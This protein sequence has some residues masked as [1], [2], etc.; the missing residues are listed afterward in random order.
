MGLSLELWVG[1]LIF[2]QFIVKIFCLRSPSRVIPILSIFFLDGIKYV[3][4]T[5]ARAINEKDL[6]YV[7]LST[8]AFVL[9]Q[10]YE[11]ALNVIRKTLT[12][13]RLVTKNGTP[14]IKL[15]E[16]TS[17]ETL[18]N[19]LAKD[20]PA[21]VSFI[22]DRL[23]KY[24]PLRNALSHGLFWF[25]RESIFYLENPNS[26]QAETITLLDF[27]SFLPEQTM[28]SQCLLWITGK[29]LQEQFFEP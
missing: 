19:L 2:Q 14:W 22:R 24:K 16:D 28:F 11:S 6:P 9:I 25:E 15:I 18:F 17:P 21:T 5:R 7:Y 29:L 20:S 8:F 23:F 12:T 13:M 26:H 27:F 4:E 1:F 3:P 10:V